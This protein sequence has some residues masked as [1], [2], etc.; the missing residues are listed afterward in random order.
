MWFLVFFLPVLF[1][2]F[3]FFLFGPSNGPPPFFFHFPRHSSTTSEQLSCISPVPAPPPQHR[4]GCMLATAGRRCL[5][6]A[7]RVYGPHSQGRAPTRRAGITRQSD[8]P[9]QYRGER[10]R[11]DRF[12]RCTHRP[13]KR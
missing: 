6:P 1:F 9:G 3:S 10:C 13:T 7:R 11:M 5:S 12:P 4:A 8:P 2:F